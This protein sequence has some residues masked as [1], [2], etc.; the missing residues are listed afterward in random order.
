MSRLKIYTLGYHGFVS[1]DVRDALT[2]PRH[3]RQASVLIAATSKQAAID[4]C[5]QTSHVHAP[6]LSD[7]E[8][9]RTSGD[10]VDALATAG[11][12]ADPVVVV[13]EL[14]RVGG[15]VVAVSASGVHRI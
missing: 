11:V 3:I 6:T 10:D 4:L 5:Q 2:L 8:F 13:K 12:F 14:T 9:R 1:R 15:P 7:P